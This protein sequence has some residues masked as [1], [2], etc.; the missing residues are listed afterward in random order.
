[1]PWCYSCLH[2]VDSCRLLEDDIITIR[3]AAWLTDGTY[4]YEDV[5]R[6]LGDVVA[7]LK[8]NL[9]VSSLQCSVTIP[10]G[11]CCVKNWVNCKSE[12]ENQSLQHCFY[13]MLFMSSCN[14]F[15]ILHI[16]LTTAHLE[17][18]SHDL[19]SIP[20]AALFL[21]TRQ[22][23]TTS[24]RIHEINGSTQQNSFLLLSFWVNG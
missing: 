21:T 19:S 16:C 20:L 10:P 2:L 24:H 6:M 3:E 11:P 1:M 7:T 8:G 15:I 22:K 18:F 23:K 9:R 12:N 4:K 5:V 13:L 17:A 14:I